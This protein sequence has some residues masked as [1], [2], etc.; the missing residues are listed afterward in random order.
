MEINRKKTGYF[1]NAA[2]LR[3]S[4]MDRVTDK[5]VFQLQ[6]IQNE[7]TEAWVEHHREEKIWISGTLYEKW[8]IVSW[9]PYSEGKFMVREDRE[10]DLYHH[11]L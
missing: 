7:W 5:S 2:L 6:F 8:S 11:G 10:G 1:R 9:S 4:W 3:I